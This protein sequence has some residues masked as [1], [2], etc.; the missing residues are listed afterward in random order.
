[1]SGF[2]PD[3]SAAA[4]E[5][6]TIW[7]GL[8]GRGD[9]F[10]D[11]PLE[12]RG[13]LIG[14]TLPA[15]PARAHWLPELERAAVTSILSL[16]GDLWLAV[17]GGPVGLIRFRRARGDR[18]GYGTGNSRLPTN[19]VTALAVTG[20]TLWV[21]TSGNPA[22]FDL[23][24][25]LWYLPRWRPALEGDSVVYEI[26]AEPVA[27]AREDPFL[28]LAAA[29]EMGSR[30]RAFVE[31]VGRLPQERILAWQRG[32]ITPEQF[33]AHPTLLPFLFHAVARRRVQFA[34][35]SLEEL[36]VQNPRAWDAAVRLFAAVDDRQ[37]ADALSRILNR[38]RDL[39]S[40]ERARRLLGSTAA[41]PEALREAIATVEAARDVASLP[42]LIEQLVASPD[43][44]VRA[45]SA[46]MLTVLGSW[47]YWPEVV[48][49][50]QKEVPTRQLEVL[51]AIRSTFAQWGTARP[52]ALATC[53]I[54]E[55]LMKSS[56]VSQRG[57]EAASGALLPVL[58]HAAIRWQLD[59]GADVR[60]LREAIAVLVEK[61]FIRADQAPG[62][63]GEQGFLGAW[64]ERQGSPMLRGCDDFAQTL[65]LAF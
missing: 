8:G 65:R 16:E 31:A 56:G 19:D 37:A 30:S 12:L 23:R 5:G 28:R 49:R 27:Y 11:M 6:D 57:R 46:R 58:P 50:A 43:S 54:A 20:D 17:A 51:A 62:P 44:S 59:N 35:R 41:E 45:G 42:A 22:A 15:G 32:Q 2:G 4:R 64:G 55:S 39:S 18:V 53:R 1:M 25:G 48:A 26:T 13:G 29:L 3:P 38:T 33:L 63:G 40:V 61:G 34:Q 7:I 24:T 21:A 60:W 36:L 47:D 14:V 10:S 52:S 9:P